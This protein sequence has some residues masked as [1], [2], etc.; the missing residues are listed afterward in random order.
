MEWACKCILRR[1]IISVIVV[2]S[3]PSWGPISPSDLLDFMG[4]KAL[5]S[6][7]RASRGGR[8]GTDTA[9]LLPLYS[10]R[11]TQRVHYLLNEAIAITIAACHRCCSKRYY[12]AVRVVQ[13][14]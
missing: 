9:P 12:S 5:L 8:T 1:T 10:W 3:G 6:S 11:T 4:S 13:L 14:L 2:A 7:Q